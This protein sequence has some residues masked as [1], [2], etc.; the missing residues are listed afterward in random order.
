MMCY[1]IIA[2]NEQE[3]NVILETETLHE[4]IRQADK[5]LSAVARFSLISELNDL[6]LDCDCMR[7]GK[8]NQLPDKF[9][10]P[11]RIYN[12]ILAKYRLAIKEIV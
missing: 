6:Q 5:I 4:A 12:Y 11:L 1:E 2:T 10:M 9:D 3:S 7:G 8:K